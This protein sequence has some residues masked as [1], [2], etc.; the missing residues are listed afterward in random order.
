MP[1]PWKV[2]STRLLAGTKEVARG[3][4]TQT[5]CP[6]ESAVSVTVPLGGSVLATHQGQ[7]CGTL[8]AVPEA[9]QA[10]VQGGYTIT[11]MGTHTD[12]LETSVSQVTVALAGGSNPNTFTIPQEGETE[13]TAASDA[14]TF[15][16][17]PCISSLT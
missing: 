17:T 6:P 10:A 11:L 8:P 4:A 3:I 12:A 1:V 5:A 16:C 7:T 15:T 9:L 14:Y 2:F 13:W